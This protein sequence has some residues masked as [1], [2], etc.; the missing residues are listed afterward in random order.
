MWNLR[1]LNAEIENR[2]IATISGATQ[3]STFKKSCACHTQHGD[4]SQHTLLFIW[5]VANGNRCLEFS[6][7]N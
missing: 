1:Q 3:T 4:Y 7:Q 6:T 2:L 5:K